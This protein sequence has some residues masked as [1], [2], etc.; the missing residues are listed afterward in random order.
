VTPARA[1]LGRVRPGVW[2]TAL[3]LGSIAVRVVLAGRTVSPWI[4]VDELIYSE[5]GK[6]LAASGEFLVRGVPSTGY[7]FVYPVLLA[8]A[9]GLFDSVPAAYHLA[10]LVNAV[11]MSLTAVPVYFLARRLLTTGLS[12]GAAALSVLLPSMLYTETLMTENAFYPLFA[13]ASLILVLTLERPTATRQ[14]A[15]LGVCAVCFATRAQAVALLGATLLAPLLHGVVERDLRARLRRYTPLYGL[16]G[17]AAALALLSTVARGRSP[18]SLLGA[19]RAATGSDYSVSEVAHYL[20]WH[21]AE[22]DLYLGI[23]GVAALIA[24][25]LAPRTLTPPA[26]AFVAATLPITLLLLAEVAVFAS[27][28]S[29]RIEERNDFYVAPFALIALVGLLSRD[30]VIPQARRVRVVAGVI[31]GV[32]PVA[33]PF[34][35]FVTTS[36]VSDTLGL[37]PWW[38]LQDQ[39]IHFGP[40]RLVALGVGVAGGAAFVLLPRRYAVALPVA[41]GVYFVLA[42]AVIENGRHGIRRASAGALF[43]GIRLPHPDW[44]DRRVGRGADVSFLWHYTGETRPLWNNEF[45]NRS[46]RD[47]YTVDGPDPADGGLPETPVFERADGT[48][49]TASR[50]V[51]RVRY[52]VSYVDIAGTPLARDPRIGLT[53]FRVDGPMVV[54]TRVRGVYPDTWGGRVVTYRRARCRGGTLSVRLGTDEHLFGSAQTVTARS[55]GRVVAR[56]RIEPAEQPTLVVPLRPG[57]GGNCTVVFTADKLRTPG[58]GDRRRL[59]AH[60][61]SF[62]YRR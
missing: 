57:A 23:V 50:S 2:L 13:A 54:L 14:L 1:R 52:A 28:Q 21:A 6:S 15:L 5:L 18:L 43:A 42:S 3:V 34:G 11:V 17:A 8:P 47:V 51:P 58:P 59:G 30:R 56:A 9:F 38:W 16:A 37:L 12:L 29:G 7:G 62:D 40:L 33:V 32:L 60:Y 44:I 19:Y 49:V 55:G 4:M 27:R 46:V 22:L 53:L 39:G 31:A 61:Y 48:L 36:A 41:V 35:R 20:L 45:F 10:K 24:M 26:R 25:W